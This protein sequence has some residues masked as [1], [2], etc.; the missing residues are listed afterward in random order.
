MGIRLKGGLSSVYTAIPRRKK[1]G[2]QWRKRGQ[3]LVEYAMIMVMVAI[4]IIVILTFIGQVVFLGL[5]SKIGS[6]MASVP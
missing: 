2:G 4:V 1:D 5:Y 6:S 3:G